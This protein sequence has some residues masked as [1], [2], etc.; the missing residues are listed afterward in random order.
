MQRLSP[1]THPKHT[2]TPKSD[3]RACAKCLCRN[4]FSKAFAALKWE[5]RLRLRLGLF[6]RFLDIIR[7]IDRLISTHYDTTKGCNTTTSIR[8]ALTQR[9]V[10]S[11]VPASSNGP[12]LPIISTHSHASSPGLLDFNRLG[13]DPHPSWIFSW[14]LSWMCFTISFIDFLQGKVYDGMKI[15][16]EHFALGQAIQ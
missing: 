3:H 4:P 14:Y 6:G 13:M 10:C 1:G 15:M 2:T 5:L 12:L 8:F 9:L 16:A 7:I 11:P